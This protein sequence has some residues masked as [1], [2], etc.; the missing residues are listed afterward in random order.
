MREYTPALLIG[1]V[2]NFQY[3]ARESI[4]VW[5]VWLWDIRAMAFL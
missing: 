1:I 5:L 4:Q 3:K 2:T